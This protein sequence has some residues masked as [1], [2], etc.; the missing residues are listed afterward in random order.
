MFLSS[1]IQQNG[2]QMRNLC[3]ISCKKRKI[4]ATVLILCLICGLTPT[5]ESI[6][7]KLRG[8]IALAGILS[9]LAY[10]THVLVKRDRRAMEKLQL[11]LG[12]PDRVV[13]FERGFDLWRINYYTEQCYLFRNNRFVK[14]VPCSSLQPRYQRFGYQIP[15]RLKTSQSKFTPPFLID[16]PV[17]GNPKWLPL[18]LLRPQRVPQFVSSDLH[19]LEDGHLLDPLPW[20][21]R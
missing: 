3:Q 8:K 19:R 12:P 14:T 1:L 6:S 10:A 20:L 7:V 21:S 16:T 2:T 18:S 5:A 17:S 4:C 13:Q 11:H 9:G 15:D